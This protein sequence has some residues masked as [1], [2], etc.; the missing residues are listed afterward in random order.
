MND[1]YEILKEEVKKVHKVI[2]EIA[3]ENKTVDNIF[4]GTQIMFS[5]LENFDKNQPKILLLG[6]NPGWGYFQKNN[7]IVEKFDELDELEYKNNNYQLAENIRDFFVNICQMEKLFETNVVKSN[8]FYFATENFEAY[9]KLTNKLLEIEEFKKY[10]NNIL[11]S[12]ERNPLF[13]LAKRWTKTLIEDIIKPDIII[14]EGVKAK[15]NFLSSIKNDDCGLK[16][17]FDPE[18]TIYLKRF[19]SEISNEEKI[20]KCKELKKLLNKL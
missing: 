8:F 16:I 14:F 19:F 13:C 18:K 12:E 10:A 17:N 15:D 11:K 6:I 3:K 4:A 9:E 7:E 2:K 1:K 5:Q 20:E